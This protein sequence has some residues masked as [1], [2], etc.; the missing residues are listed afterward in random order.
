MKRLS[1]R[2]AAC[3][4]LVL[5]AGLAG[6][7][8]AA[9][10]GGAVGAG[11]LLMTADRRSGETQEADR[12]IEAAAGDAVVRALPGRGHVNITSYYRKVLIT[13]E[14]PSAQDSQLVAAQ[15]RAVPGVA[16]VVNELAV[17]PESST[18]Q[19]SNDGLITSKVRTRLMN[20]NGVPAG[21]IR[22]TTERGTTY[23]MGRLTATETALA[24]EVARQTDGVQRVVRVIDLIADPAGGS[25]VTT[26]AAP[27]ADPAVSGTA[28][29][30]LPAAGDQA[31]GVVVSPVTQPVIEQPRPPVQVQTLPPMK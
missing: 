3:A 25:S 24:T 15:V 28:A 9:L 10:V 19:R 21:S 7:V 31:T 4:T 5:A 2:A 20:Q 26:S 14:V 8:P 6:C 17:M 12:T 18:L 30:T 29:P 13:G 22:V 23:L 1:L 16:G 11:A 27:V